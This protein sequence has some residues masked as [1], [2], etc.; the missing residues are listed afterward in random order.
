MLEELFP[1]MEVGFLLSLPAG[2]HVACFGVDVQEMMAAVTLRPREQPESFGGNFNCAALTWRQVLS[3]PQ[4]SEKTKAN[5]SE[6][7]EVQAAAL[8]GKEATS[9]VPMA[10]GAAQL[11]CLGAQVQLLPALPP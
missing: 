4:C 3:P 11:S 6:E 7:N 9:A 2:V 5:V 1:D 10:R 8:G